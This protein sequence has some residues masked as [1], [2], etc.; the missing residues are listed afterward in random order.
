MSYFEDKKLINKEFKE[1]EK[2]NN[3]IDD[4]V[5]L[6]IEEK[7]SADFKELMKKGYQE[8][9]ELNLELSKLGFEKMLNDVNE[10]ETWL[11]GV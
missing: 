1:N 7:D 10:Y 6:Y 5:I 11:C 4:S 3:S 8:M 9:A 2:N